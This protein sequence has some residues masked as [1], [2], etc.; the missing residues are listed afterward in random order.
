MD[1]MIMNFGTDACSSRVY[2]A[3]KRTRGPMVFT[4]RFRE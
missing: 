3:W 1:E 2:A 4:C